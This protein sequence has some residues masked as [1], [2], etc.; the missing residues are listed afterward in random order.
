MSAHTFNIPAEFKLQCSDIHNILRALARKQEEDLPV[1]LAISNGNSPYFYAKTEMRCDYAD[2]TVGWITEHSSVREVEELL[3]V[4][5]N[6]LITITDEMDN[7][8]PEDV[9]CDAAYDRKV[10]DALCGD[11]NLFIQWFVED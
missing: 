6:L 4:A 5:E 10:D 1:C 11:E 7:Y 9:L 2:I 8:W 3:Q